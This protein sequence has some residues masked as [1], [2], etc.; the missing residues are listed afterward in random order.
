[1]KFASLLN[2]LFWIQGHVTL[3]SEF[4][5]VVQASGSGTE[6]LQHQP[7]MKIN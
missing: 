4:L 7:M 3:A 1:M 2:L 6:E 5:I